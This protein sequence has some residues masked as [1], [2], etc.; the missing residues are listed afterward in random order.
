MITLSVRHEIARHLV[1]L[2]WMSGI[3]SGINKFDLQR[4]SATKI[5][6]KVVSVSFGVQYT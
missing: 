5:K 6:S 2:L 1:W 3:L 4:D